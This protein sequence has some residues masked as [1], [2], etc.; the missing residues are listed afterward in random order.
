MAVD[1]YRRRG[2][3]AQ[4]QAARATDRLAKTDFEQL[5]QEW[6]ALAERAEW[7][8]RSYGPLLMPGTGQTASPVVQ[9]QQ[10]QIQPKDKK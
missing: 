7:L 2:F 3:E 5:A 10:Q 9:Q 1:E 6:F 4:R 8:E